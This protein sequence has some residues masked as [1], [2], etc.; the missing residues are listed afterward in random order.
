MSRLGGGAVAGKSKEWGPIRKCRETKVNLQACVRTLNFCNDFAGQKS[1]RRNNLGVPRLTDE[2]LLNG[3]SQ[4]ATPALRVDGK[5]EGSRIARMPN[6][7]GM[8]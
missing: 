8:K 3:A 7:D 1:L 6:Q 4:N 5:M 2:E